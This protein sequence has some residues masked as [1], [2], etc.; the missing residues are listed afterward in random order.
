VGLQLAASADDNDPTA[1]AAAADD[2]DPFRDGV[3]RV[4]GVSRYDSVMRSIELLDRPAASAAGAV[5]AALIEL[6]RVV[7]VLQT[8]SLDGLDDHEV[9]AVFGD[10]EAQR[11]RLPT[12]DHRLITELE[13]RGTAT[14]L[15]ARG[16]A[17]LLT[18][19]LHVDVSA[20]KSR[21]RAAGVCWG[22]APRS[23]VNAH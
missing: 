7:D 16:T 1:S 22:R 15:L 20:A 12:V 3:G 2:C 4:V 19:L 17:G 8:G 9:L 5:R 11:R 6:T 21:V 13:C 23:P 10:L 14:K 18:E